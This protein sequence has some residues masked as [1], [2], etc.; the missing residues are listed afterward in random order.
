V[1]ISIELSDT[2]WGLICGTLDAHAD[3]ADEYVEQLDMD[4]ED[5]ID[6]SVS[7]AAESRR[8]AGY[9]T[10]VVEHAYERARVNFSNN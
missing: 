4:E 5:E 10:T 8:I 9:I 3:T 2:D 6:E 7:N 1:I